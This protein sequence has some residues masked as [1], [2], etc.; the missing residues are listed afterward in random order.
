MVGVLKLSL[1]LL[2][3][4][5]AALFSRTR[6]RAAP[7][8]QLRVDALAALLA[9]GHE[10]TKQLHGQLRMRRAHSTHVHKHAHSH[11]STRKS[12]CTHRPER[13]ARNATT[14]VPHAVEHR[15]A[16]RQTPG[17][18]GKR[19]QHTSPTKQHSTKPP[20]APGG[21]VAAR[22]AAQAAACRAESGR[23]TGRR[24]ANVFKLCVHTRS[25]H[26]AERCSVDL[27][28]GALVA[29][30]GE[31]GIL[32][33]GARAVHGQNEVHRPAYRPLLFLR[34][35]MHTRAHGP[36]RKK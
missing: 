10:V 30:A 31:G 11:K 8:H 26:A 6:R 2:V 21:A 7:S 25:A 23:T 12:W 24:A 36:R 20:N 32:H 9:R 4:L 3:F 13:V 35:Q 5:L 28:D 15:Q 33:V 16:S 22:P 19:T 17:A 27:Q 14:I 1:R 18:R 29:H 34:A